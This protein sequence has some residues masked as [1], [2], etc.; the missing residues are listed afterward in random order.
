MEPS[1]SMSISPVD[2]QS[3]LYASL[4]EARTADVVLRVSGTWKAVYRLHRVVLIQAV[5]PITT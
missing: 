5:S 1:R 3:H 4:L 2:L